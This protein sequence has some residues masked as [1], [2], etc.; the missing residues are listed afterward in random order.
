M[1]GTST[2]LTGWLPPSTMKQIPLTQGKFALI[3]DSDYE[4][5]NQF[6][7]LAH[8]NWKGENFYASRTDC[9]VDPPIHV[10]MA[11]FILN[12]P[13]DMF[14]DHKNHDT[15]DNQRNNLR[16]C[17]P[18]QNQYNARSRVNSSSKY[19]GISWSKSHKNWHARIRVVNIFGQ[20]IVQN[21]GRFRDEK[22]A[23]LAYDKAAKEH[24]EEFAY[25]NFPRVEDVL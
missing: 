11:R 5:V 4:R 20:S 1:A 15:L 12:C 7:W 10:T 18:R 13:K 14:V 17:T 2:A 3:D 9:S 22:E 25:L 19:K 6:K 8:F 23:A 24:H 16:V 21:L